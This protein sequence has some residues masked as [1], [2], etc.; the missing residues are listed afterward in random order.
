MSTSPRVLLILAGDSLSIKCSAEG[1]PDNIFQWS[2][3]GSVL[4]N[5]T[6]STLVLNI[7]AVAVENLGNYTCMV[8]NAAGS[9]S[10]TSILHGNFLPACTRFTSNFVYFTVL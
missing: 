4:A 2:H 7:T 5:G 10:S 6:T 3:N 9:D 8:T 1:G